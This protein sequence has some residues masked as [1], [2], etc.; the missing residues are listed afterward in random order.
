[1]ALLWTSVLTSTSI[2]LLTLEESV[3]ATNP[4]FRLAMGIVTVTFLS[5]PLVARA[6][7]RSPR[8]TVLVGACGVVGWIASVCYGLWAYTAIGGGP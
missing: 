3:V 4:A 8:V 1:M 6:L 2:G 7:H 5:A